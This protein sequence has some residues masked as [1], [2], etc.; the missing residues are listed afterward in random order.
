VVLRRLCTYS[1][2]A[3]NTPEIF[4]WELISEPGCTHPYMSQ[5][6]NG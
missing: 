1:T 6:E 3:K 4:S 5:E 2:V